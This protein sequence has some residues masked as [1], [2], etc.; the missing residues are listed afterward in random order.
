[1]TRIPVMAVDPSLRYTGV[2]LGH[3]NPETG[4]VTIDRV[5]LIE[6]EKTKTK[7]IRKNSDD[8]RCARHIHDTLNQLRS[9]WG[10]VIT[11]VEVPSGTQS[12][13]A[14]WTLGVMLGLIA[15]WPL[16]LIELSATEV[17]KHFAGD[18]S[19]SKDRMITR[20]TELHPELE[21]LTRGGRLLNKNEHLADAVAILHTGVA[22]T[23]FR[24]LARML[25]V[26]AA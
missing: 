16:P 12:A 17:K 3:T 18:R 15:T 23:Q 1:M 20:A 7:S 10:P 25:A 26:R 9:E 4:S 21:W 8:L 6:T 24:E 14:S 5:H 2:A 22:S 13:R 19:A 11:M